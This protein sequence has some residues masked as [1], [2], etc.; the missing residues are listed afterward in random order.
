MAT[1]AQILA[2]RENSKLSTGPASP[3]GKAVSSQNHKSHGFCAADP[4]LP[5]EDRNEFNALLD[6]YKS[7]WTPGTEHQEFLVSQM[8]GARWKLARLE[9]IEV[10]M[11]AALDSPEKAFS[12]K[13]TAAGFAK[14]ERYRAALERTYHRCV[15]ELRVSRKEQQIQNEPKS[16]QIAENNYFDRLAEGMAIRQKRHAERVRH[17]PRSGWLDEL[18]RLKGGWSMGLDVARCAP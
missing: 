3:E 5:T 9:R 16:K 6:E 11:L 14:L 10:S 7:E 13:E 4:V 15:R 17:P 12:D 2:N 18:G 8:T 1:Q